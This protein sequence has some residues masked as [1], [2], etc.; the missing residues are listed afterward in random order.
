MSGA[1]SAINT[2]FGHFQWNVGRLG[3]VAAFSL[4]IGGVSSSIIKTISDENFRNIAK[5]FLLNHRKIFAA[6]VFLL[7]MPLGIRALY[8]PS[9]AVTAIY[10]TSYVLSV[11]WG[12]TS[13]NSLNWLELNGYNLTNVDLSKLPSHLKKLVIEDCNLERVNLSKLPLSLWEFEVITSSQS[14]ELECLGA[15]PRAAKVA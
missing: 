15:A 9:L 5:I 3:K 13:R 12:V 1:I 11:L 4:V 14:E 2:Q 10:V 8:S 6:K 7:L